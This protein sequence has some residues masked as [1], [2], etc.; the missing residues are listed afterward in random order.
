MRSSLP[1]SR[2][3]SRRRAG[4][5]ATWLNLLTARGRLDEALGQAQRNYELTERLGDVFTRTW[6]L[7]NLSLVRT[8]KGDGDGALDAIERAIRIDDEAMG[9][10]GEAEAWRG[11]ALV[12]A[13]L[14]A[15]RIEEARDAAEREL[16]NRA[17]A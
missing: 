7:V 1:T 12:R 9:M 17:R 2:V 13:F 16:P 5:A 10:G 15:G 14:C 8:E 6:A 11:M 3:T 4:V